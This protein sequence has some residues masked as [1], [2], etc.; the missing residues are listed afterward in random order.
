M[1]TPTQRLTAVKILTKIYCVFFRTADFSKRSRP[2]LF[3]A[4]SHSESSNVMKKEFYAPGRQVAVLGGGQLGTMMATAAQALRINIHCL[5][6]SLDAPAA[7]NAQGFA[8]GEF[9]DRHTVEAF[10]RNAEVATIE[11]EKVSVDGLKALR[12]KHGVAVHPRPEALELIQDKGLQKEFYRKENYPTAPYQLW[13]SA[14]DIKAAF[15]STSSRQAGKTQLTLPF[16]QKS[17]KGGYDGKG[18]HV[19]R[20]EA[21]LNELLEGPSLTE[22]FAPLDIEIAVV[23]ARNPSGQT[24]TF[25][26]VEMDFDPKQNLVTQLISP[27]RISKQVADEAR[28]IAGRLIEQLDICGLLAV[29]LFLLKDGSLWVNEVAPR[30]HNSGHISMNGFATSQFE[31][32]LRGI[33]DLP[34]GSTQQYRPAVMVNLLGEEGATGPAVYRGLEEVIALPG[35][36]VHLYGKTITKPHR[37]MG[38]VNIVAD[39][40]EEALA[41]AEKVRNTLSATTNA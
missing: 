30:P 12:D 14:A 20:T 17:R 3:F 29:E 13:N 18:V 31:Q 38:H 33:L 19:V 11:I 37:K 28:A 1:K 26:V 15:L 9:T 8:E 6:P 16:V 21:D 5:D 4:L 10:G 32:H 23:A 25:P 34:L 22:D 7:Y 35:V 36:H 41:L 2:I 40:L 27:A 24:S 39:T